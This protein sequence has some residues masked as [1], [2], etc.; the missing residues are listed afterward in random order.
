MWY[1]REFVVHL[2]FDVSL[3]F[4]VYLFD[5]KKENGAGEWTR[6]TDLLITNQLL[7]QTELHRRES[8]EVYNYSPRG[9]MVVF[10]ECQ[11]NFRKVEPYF[12]STIS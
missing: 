12:L 9:A 11:P 5:K 1:N 10:F 3:S 2:W 8:R 4:T 6:T 7:R